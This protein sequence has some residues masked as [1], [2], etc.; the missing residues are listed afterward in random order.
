MPRFYGRVV[1]RFLVQALEGEDLTVFGDG[2]QTRSFC[3]VA[4]TVTGLLLLCRGEGLA[5]EAVNLGSREETS[6][7]DLARKI[8]RLSSSSSRISFQPFPPGDHRRRLPDGEKT[9]KTIHW[10]PRIGLD[11][12]LKRTLHWF[13]NKK[14]A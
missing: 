1:S 8:V 7:I 13:S 2:S 11:E 12:G 3:Y 9:R 4:D 6:V 5:G 14:S 10:G